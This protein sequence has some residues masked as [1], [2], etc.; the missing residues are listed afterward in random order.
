MDFEGAI[1]VLSV[2][3]SKYYNACIAH[4]QASVAGEKLGGL[5]SC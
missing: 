3:S 2:V 1:T 5:P 4:V